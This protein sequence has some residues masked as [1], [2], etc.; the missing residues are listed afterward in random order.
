MARHN[1]LFLL[2]II[3][4]LLNGRLELFLR[5]SIVA[6][7][8]DHL[9]LAFINC[10]SRRLAEVLLKYMT[11]MLIELAGANATDRSYSASA[12]SL[13]LVTSIGAASAVCA[14]RLDPNRVRR[15]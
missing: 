4:R 3:F 11:V 10:V 13:M 12:A 5:G 2:H 6:H 1:R 14:D 8:T 15:L 7:F 9:S